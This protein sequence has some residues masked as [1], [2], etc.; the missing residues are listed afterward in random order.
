MTERNPAGK[1][2][3]DLNDK[4]GEALIHAAVPQ[5][6]QHAVEQLRGTRHE[7]GHVVVGSIHAR[8]H[9]LSSKC[10]VIVV[11]QSV[12]MSGDCSIVQTP[13]K[14]AAEETPMTSG[15]TSGLRNRL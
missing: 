3:T 4:L 9:Q 13:A 15:E 8:Y 6:P 11:H 14:E 12:G 7:L 5:P 2:F 10:C 1:L